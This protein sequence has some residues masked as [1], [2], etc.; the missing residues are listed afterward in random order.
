MFLSTISK[1][2]FIVRLCSTDRRGVCIIVS[3]VCT[4]EWSWLVQERDFYMPREGV[5]DKILLSGGDSRLQLVRISVSTMEYNATFYTWNYDSRLT[6]VWRIL[7]T[8]VFCMKGIDRVEKTEEEGSFNYSRSLSTYRTEP[9][10]RM[11]PEAS[12][13]E[14][15]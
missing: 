2:N 12:S 8:P 13:V 15:F 4:R 10:F 1:S 3:N 14:K 11:P 6:P 7:R 9:V 5:S